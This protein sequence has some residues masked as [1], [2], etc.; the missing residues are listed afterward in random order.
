VSPHQLCIEFDDPM[1]RRRDQPR[2]KSMCRSDQ[3]TGATV[4]EIV[5]AQLPRRSFQSQLQPGRWIEEVV[6][7]LQFARKNETGCDLPSPDD[8]ERQQSSKVQTGWFFK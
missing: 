2:Q 6:E 4:P 5:P 8:I 3:P 1:I 7:T